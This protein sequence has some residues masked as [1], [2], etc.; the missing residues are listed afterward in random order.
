MLQLGYGPFDYAQGSYAGLLSGVEA[1][2]CFF[3]FDGGPFDCAQGS[4]EDCAQGAYGG[5][6]SGSLSG[7]FFCMYRIGER[8]RTVGFFGGI[9]IL[10]LFFLFFI[11]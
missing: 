1:A 5:M 10:D 3:L 6:R 4:Y 8:S 7:L 11:P 9:C 2:C